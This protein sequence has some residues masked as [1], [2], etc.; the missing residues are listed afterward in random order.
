MRHP[1]STSFSGY[2]YRSPVPLRPRNKERLKKVDRFQTLFACLKADEML[3]DADLERRITKLRVED[4]ASGK[5]DDVSLERAT[6][7]SAR[8][9]HALSSGGA[10]SVRTRGFLATGASAL[11]LARGRLVDPELNQSPRVGWDMEVRKQP[12]KGFG[13]K[14]SKLVPQPTFQDGLQHRYEHLGASIEVDLAL[15][16]VPCPYRNRTR[17]APT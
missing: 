4:Y 11:C 16:S 14:L 6:A 3:R 7:S 8:S 9:C 1:V 2:R 15:A 5:F 17:H 10:G 13:G 12:C